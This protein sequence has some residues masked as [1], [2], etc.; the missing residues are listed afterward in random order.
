MW[1]FQMSTVQSV[2]YP[3]TIVGAGALISSPLTFHLFTVALPWGLAGAATASVATSMIDLVGLIIWSAVYVQRMPRSS[4][5]RQVWTGL[6]VDAFKKWGTFFELGLPSMA[7]LC[8]EWCVL[9]LQPQQ[10][11]IIFL[12]IKPP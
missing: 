4:S 1:Y 12:D 9:S 3:T 6:S 7:M 2:I 5:K 10:Y 11:L 8:L